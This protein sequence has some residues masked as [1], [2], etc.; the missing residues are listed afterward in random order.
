M[1]ENSH[2]WWE[3][4]QRRGAIDRRKFLSPKT[5]AL[6]SSLESMQPALGNMP[7]DRR[8]REIVWARLCKAQRTKKRWEL[9]FTFGSLRPSFR[10][11]FHH[12]SATAVRC[13]TAMFLRRSSLSIF[14]F[15]SLRQSAADNR[16]QAINYSLFQPIQH[17]RGGY[18][19]QIAARSNNS[20]PRVERSVRLTQPCV[21][22]VIESFIATEGG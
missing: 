19:K 1:N 3:K 4:P 8:R 17:E 18:V 5:T 12:L 22:A 6:R 15:F 13:Q 9:D 20:V 21:K 14:F 10:T 7:V 2:L 16:W 11:I